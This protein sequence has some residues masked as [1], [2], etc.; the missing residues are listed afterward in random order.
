[1]EYSSKFKLISRLIA[2]PFVLGIV[3][4]TFLMYA[5]RKWLLFVRY[6]GEWITYT[7]KEVKTIEDIYKHLKTNQNDRIH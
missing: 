6:G 2:S 4:T 1:M 3:V 5:I 7:P